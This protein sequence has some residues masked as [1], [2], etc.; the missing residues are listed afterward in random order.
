M[1]PYP[2]ESE[3]PG[4]PCSVRKLERGRACLGATVAS[5]PDTPGARTEPEC[6]GVTESQRVALQ[7]PPEVPQPTPT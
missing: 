1:G 2:D 4:W 7:M 3:M 5:R 6:S